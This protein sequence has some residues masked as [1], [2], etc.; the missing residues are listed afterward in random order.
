MKQERESAIKAREAQKKPPE[1]K[2][3]QMQAERPDKVGQGAN[4]RQNTR[5][6][7]Y[8]QDR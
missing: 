1:S 8:Q 3:Q 2:T 6:T 5:N 4:I 7:G